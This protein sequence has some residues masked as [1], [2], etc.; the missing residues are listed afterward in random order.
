M[1]NF[2]TNIARN[3][4]ARA[5]IFEDGV[6]NCDNNPMYAP[7]VS[8]DA[9]TQDAGD[10]TRIECPDPYNYGKFIEVGTIPGE[11]SR[12]TTTIT[13]RMTRDSLSDFRRYFNQ[14]CSLDIQLIYGL[15]ERPNVYGQ[16]DK[17]LVFEEVFVT[18]FGTDALSALASGDR[19]EILE[20]AD[21]SVGN[22]Y[23]I[24][25]LNYNVQGLVNAATLDPLIDGVV[26]DIQSCGVDCSNPSDGCEKLFVTDAVGG[27]LYTINAGDDWNTT[28]TSFAGVGAGTVVGIDTLN[29]WLWSYND[30]GEIVYLS[31]EGVRNGDTA[32]SVTGLTTAGLD[33]DAGWEYGLVVGTAGF[34]GYLTNPALGFDVLPDAVTASDLVDVH[35][36]VYD[37]NRDFALATGDAGAVIF[38][39]DGI[40]W[41]VSP[42]LP[43]ANDLVTGYAK[44]PLNWI[45]ASATEAWCTSDCGTTWHEIAIGCVVTDIH[46]IRRTAARNVLVMTADDADGN[47]IILRSTDGGNNWVQAVNQG[48]GS[49]VSNVP[50]N[51]VIVPCDNDPNSYW[52]V[53]NTGG[54][55]SILHGSPT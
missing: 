26:S 10:R 41:S 50:G 22:F 40:N 39:E 29:S 19:A 43:T 16:F 24:V 44:T 6:N 15:C 2:S 33:Q 47:P 13:S 48:K 4:L 36:G 30:S 3:D 14:Q 49:A 37:E 42:T 38:S 51:N 9:L 18:S 31:P 23:E 5:W 1:A 17:I 53:G 11:I 20:T 27:L 52:L 54:N 34:V 8:F 28:V 32:K 45:V 55:G 25:Q 12:L 35:I 7:C 21:I 46:D